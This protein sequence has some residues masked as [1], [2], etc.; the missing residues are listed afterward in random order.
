MQ[1]ASPMHAGY[2]GRFAPTPSGPLH[3]GSLIAALGSYL[4]AK[5]N[6]GTWQLRIDDLDPPRVAAGAADSIL[7]CLERYGLEWDGAVVWQSKRSAAYHAAMHLLARQGHTYFCS[8]SRKEISQRGRAGIDG[9]IYPGTCREQA[10]P[11]GSAH[12]IRVVVGDDELSFEDRTHG[13]ITQNLASEVGDFVLYRTDRVYAYHLAC[14]VD[15]AEQGV[16]DVVRGADLIDSTPRQIF[17]QRCLGLRT[18]RYLHLP[19]ARNA[20]GEKLSKQ[21]RASDIGK[22]AVVPTLLLA[23]RFLGQTTAGAGE[24]QSAR[25]VLE[26]AMHTWDARRIPCRQS[27]ELN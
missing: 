26:F 24:L 14:I 17:L 8:C 9:P 21:S 22:R 3:F 16:T 1:S 2:R 25:E 18:P 13:R 4:D 23:L 10:S 11:R 20:A 19:V 12:A 15:D 6:N 27:A 5:R 7:R